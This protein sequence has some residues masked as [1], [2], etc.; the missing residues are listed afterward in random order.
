MISNE[1]VSTLSS[2]GV[3]YPATLWTIAA[4]LKRIHAVWQVA[5]QGQFYINPNNYY[6]IIVGRILKSIDNPFVSYPTVP[7]FIMARFL[8]LF[9]QEDQWNQS[10]AKWLEALARVHPIH[11]KFKLSEQK[12]VF[13]ISKHTLFWFKVNTYTILIRVQ[14]IAMAT[15]DFGLQSFKLLMR[16]MD[17]VDLINFDWNTLVQRSTAESGVHVPRGLAV[18]IKP[19]NKER[20]M[21]RLEGKT[22]NLISAGHIYGIERSKAVEV[23]KVFFESLEFGLFYYEKTAGIFGDAVISLIKQGIYDWSPQAVKNYLQKHRLDPDSEQWLKQGKAKKTAS[24]P[25][26]VISYVENGAQIAPILVSSSHSAP[27]LVYIPQSP[28]YNVYE[29]N[30]RKNTLPLPMNIVTFDLYNE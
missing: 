7:F 26:N 10:K 2:Q 17:I 29:V 8:D 15:L 18:I 22:N 14:R 16:I 13:F 11:I 21:K 20:F 12:T 9:E 6:G 5:I 3:N 24:P 23:A 30:E 25:L 1:L 28:N 27:H 4:A 19:E